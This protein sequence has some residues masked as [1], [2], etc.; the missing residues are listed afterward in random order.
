MKLTTSRGV[1]QGEIL[2]MRIKDDSFETLKN[3]S[4]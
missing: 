3:M 1:R 2:S 4:C